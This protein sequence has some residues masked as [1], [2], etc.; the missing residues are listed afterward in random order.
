MNSIRRQLTIRL[1]LGTF[2]V[3]AVGLLAAFVFLR[4]ELYEQFDD[5]MLS[6]ARTLSDVVVIDD[7]RGVVD[8]DLHNAGGASEFH[9]ERRPDYFQIWT[10]D[11]AVLARS[12]SLGAR[13]LPSDPLKQGGSRRHFDLILPDGRPGRAVAFTFQPDV[14]SSTP[15]TRAAAA[16]KATKP[17]TLVLASGTQELRKNLRTLMIGLFA[18]FAALAVA[19]ALAVPAA[20][21]CGLKPLD[22]VGD[23]AAC[24]DPATL[25]T[26]FDVASMPRELR[27]VGE[28]LNE[29]LARLES[30]FRR[31]RR[32]TS[33]VAHELRTPIAELR[34][35]AEVALKFPSSDSETA[36][37]NYADVQGVARQMEAIVGALLAIAR[38]E[39]GKQAMKMSSTNVAEVIAEAW[40]PHARTTSRRQL[41]TSIE[42]P[43]DVCVLSDPLLL[44]AM[45]GNLFAN[46]VAYA[47]RGGTVR[48][49]GRVAETAK[50]FVLE[51]L[52]T[53]DSLTQ[54]DL[55]LL[56]EP[57]WRK[58]AART[59]GAHAGLGL[60][61][62]SSY[63]ELLGIGLR[64]SLPSSNVFAV[65]LA[66]PLVECKT[67]TTTTQAR[68]LTD[69]QTVRAAVGPDSA[70]VRT[71][72]EGAHV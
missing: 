45:L 58:D 49:R 35:L 53:N 27:P 23:A 4:V 39:V 19:T 16:A 25:A 67:P 54:A 68:N 7:E 33:N 29:L 64:V 59:D 52:N 10:G 69:A 32:F 72:R 43:Q 56:T 20:V 18:V 34:S 47:P 22:N 17:V 60:A 21:R 5:A 8:F 65:E 24:I 38:C 14:E 62:V 6:R 9:R 63:A 66:V 28:K 57:F 61:L 2:V 36:S 40:K 44:A 37:R 46:A 71:P 26:R 30:A 3:A 31:E 42:V 48:C 15:T 50:M 70:D 11:G 55:P 51:V 1:V 41:L 13:D 12:A